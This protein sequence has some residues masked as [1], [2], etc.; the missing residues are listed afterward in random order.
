MSILPRVS[1][2]TRELASRE[3]DDIG[4]AASVSQIVE[5][6]QR[7]NPELLHMASQWVNDLDDRDPVMTAFSMFYRLLTA[8]LG[9]SGDHLGLSPLP[10]VSDEARTMIVERIESEGDERFSLNALVEMDRSNPELLEMAHYF[11]SDRA[12]YAQVMGGF[13]L[14]Y[15]TLQLQSDIDRRSAH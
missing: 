11:A 9:P 1:P 12:D 2:S 7:N 13:A 8:E 10:R 6:L 15:A 14:L 5:E 3:F 4:P